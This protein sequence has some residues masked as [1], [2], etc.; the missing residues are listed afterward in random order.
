MA[1]YPEWV[2]KYKPKGYYVNKYKDY[3]RIEIEK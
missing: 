1:D 2:L 3:F